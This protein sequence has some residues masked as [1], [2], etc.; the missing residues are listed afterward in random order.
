[1]LFVAVPRLA[2]GLQIRAPR[3]DSG[4]GLSGRAQQMVARPPR[5][6]C[7]PV[8]ACSCAKAPQGPHL[9]QSLSNSYLA[10]G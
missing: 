8:S 3:F 7:N 1:V 6:I 2:K 5:G 9:S 10:P 4:R